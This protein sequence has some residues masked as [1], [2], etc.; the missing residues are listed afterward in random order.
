MTNT[1]VVYWND[2]TQTASASVSIVVGVVPG[3]SVLGGTAWHDADFDDIQDLGERALAGWTVELYRD[4]GLQHSA[5]TDADGAYRIVGVAPNDVINYQYELRFRAPGA[6]ANTAPLGIASS[7]FTNALQRISDIVVPS[8]ANV[9]SLNLPIDPNGVVY[10]S[11][12]RTPVAGA[13]LTLH[14]RRQRRSAAGRLLL[15]LGPAGAGHARRRL[16]QV[17]PQFQRRGLSERRGIPG[18]GR[19]AGRDHLRRGVLAGHSADV[20]RLDRGRS[21]CRPARAASDDVIPGTALFCEVQG[22]EFAPAASV[23]ART[24]GTVYH[25]HL[26]LDD[27][28]VPGSSQIFNNHIPLDPD[29]ERRA[30]RSRR[31]RRFGT[32]RAANSC[33]TSI[34]VSNTAGLPLTDVAIVDRFPAGFSYVEGSA[35]IDGVAVEPAIAGRELTWGGLTIASTGRHTL[36]LLLAVGAGVGE[37][38]F[39]NRAQVV[40]GITGN[41]MSGEATA[42]VRVTAGPDLRLHGRHGQGVRRRATAMASRRTARPAFRACAC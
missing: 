3:I 41:T 10:N 31:P 35:Q 14:E 17:R 2:P 36:K 4:G 8:N 25:L 40:H 20:R 16:L 18:R 37:G 22:S 21:P 12:S 26:T 28:Q 27:S 6:G 42:T 34:T 24:A 13:T 7:P 30:R 23:P 9:L 15:R 5:V 38:E 33:R 19:S 1:G 11:V 39:V 29:V 32:S